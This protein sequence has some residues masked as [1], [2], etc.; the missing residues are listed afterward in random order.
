MKI[1]LIGTFD[2]ENFGDCMFPELYAHLL[3]RRFNS[4]EVALFSPTSR[5]AEILSYTIVHG[6]PQYED[7]TGLAALDA[8][9]LLLIGGE[10]IGH[11]HSSGTFNFRRATL[12]AYLRLWLAPIL[13]TRAADQRP[14]YFAAQS[15]GAIKMPKDV[16]IEV[17]ACLVAADR[18]RFRD[19]FSVEW[20]RSE[21]IEFEADVDPMFL[22]DQIRSEA[23]WQ[24]HAKAC[25][26]DDIEPGGYIAA[27]VSLGYGRNDFTAW[28]SS[29]AEIAEQENKPVVLVPICHFMEDT[30]L[31]S[32]LEP[33]LKKAGVRVHL[34]PGLRNV[35]ETAALVAMAAGYVG[36]SLHGAV[37]SVAFGRPIAVLGH[38]LDG[39]HAGTLAS[40]GVTGCVT[41]NNHELPTC[42][43]ASLAR[44]RDADRR[45]AHS[46]A[47]KSIDAL[48]DAIE[49]KASEACTE[50]F[51]T[52]AT[53]LIARE[54]KPQ[55]RQDIKRVALRM[56]R[57][58]SL[59]S[60]IYYRWRVW[61]AFRG[62]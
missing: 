41:T 38:S 61:K 22:I 1:G 45:V 55:I 19:N 44:D 51:E 20:I 23:D 52:A 36:S 37:T 26:P 50:Y 7:R 48:F 5:A 58:M 9:V 54:R 40:V 10:T 62:V 8:D 42:F 18:V 15:V 46:R 32:K 13:A 21:N 2:V 31:L 35:K 4:V 57:K 59:V 39:K 33:M 24:A 53:S 56:I 11:G 3:S 25:L 16:S 12:S 60:F 14:Y 6:L 29:I 43:R 49:Q 27:Q 47:Q 34:V 30:R 28:V 17:A